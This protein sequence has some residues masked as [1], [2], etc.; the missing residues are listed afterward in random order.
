MGRNLFIMET[1]S[2]YEEFIRLYE[3][4]Y[5]KLYEKPKDYIEE[6]E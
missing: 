3:A 6:D 5:G 2:Q 4:I 1:D